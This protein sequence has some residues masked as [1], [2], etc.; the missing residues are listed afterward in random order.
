MGS[1]PDAKGVTTGQK[2]YK[3]EKSKPD[4]YRDITDRIIIDMEQGRFPWVQP[5]NASYAACSVGLPQN[6]AT[7]NTY[8]GINILILWGS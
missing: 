3:S 2:I 5:W 6:S 8:S 7:Y 4:L 1:R